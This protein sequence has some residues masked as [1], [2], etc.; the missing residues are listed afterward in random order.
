MIKAVFFDIDG[1]LVS[2]NT[3]KISKSSKNA[4]NKLRENGIRVFI[5]TGRMMFQIDNLEDLQFEG[6]I[7]AN[8]TNCFANGIEILKNPIPKEDLISF[9]SYLKNVDNIPSSLITNSNIY[10]NYMTDDIK[11]IFDMM[12]IKCPDII[13]FDYFIHNNADDIL[14]V[15]LFLE[16]NS[17]NAD[18]EKYILDNI[19][20]NSLSSRWHPL[21]LDINVKNSGK[22]LGI[23]KI[24]NHYNID[25]SETMSFGDGKNDISMIKHTAIGIA[26]GNANEEVKKVADYITDDVDNDGIYKA[27]KHF[28]LI[29]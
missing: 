27:L 24:I 16:D 5:A 21:F 12:K 13:D 29:D 11:Y 4:I 2:F 8:G 1:T 7:T 20:K 3:H 28:N 9:L 22:H 15:N 14:Q 10:V 19:F 25:L 6:Y 23:D 26:M 18:R 17:F